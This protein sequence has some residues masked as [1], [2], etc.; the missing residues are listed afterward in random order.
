MPSSSSKLRRILWSV[1]SSKPYLLNTSLYGTGLTMPN[2]ASSLTRFYISS[3]KV[4]FSPTSILR[5]HQIQ[6]KSGAPLSKM[7]SPNKMKSQSRCHLVLEKLMILQRA[8]IKTS[9][10]FLEDDMDVHNS[11]RFVDLPSFQNCL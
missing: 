6:T 8:W 9:R 1:N 5:R 4:F 11:S 3:W 10:R 7:P 2:Q